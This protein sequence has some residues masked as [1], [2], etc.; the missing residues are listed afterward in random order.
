MRHHV[1]HHPS[2]PPP[3]SWRA[4]ETDA[5]RTGKPAAAFRRSLA[6]GL[7]PGPPRSAAGCELA[8]A[9][10][11]RR[12]SCPDM[13][14]YVRS[15]FVGLAFARRKKRGVGSPPPVSL[16]AYDLF[17]GHILYS[18]TSSLFAVLLHAAEYPAFCALSF[19]HVLGACQAG[20]TLEGDPGRMAWRNAL[21]AGGRLASLDAGPA[22]PVA[23]AL[24]WPELAPFATLQESDLGTWV[25]DVVCMSACGVGGGGVVSFEGPGDR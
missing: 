21:A 16:T 14:R 1:V 13:E 9:S 7:V 12:F 17:H 4:M 25:G 6:P 15:L 22:S 2:L 11:G 18:R 24:V 20:S 5:F 19:P 10:S 3:P 8:P 23:A